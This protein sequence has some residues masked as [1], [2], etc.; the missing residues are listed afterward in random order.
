MVVSTIGK[1]IY[2]TVTKKKNKLPTGMAKTAK[3]TRM[4]G[5]KMATKPKPK[6]TKPKTKGY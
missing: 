4:P 1:K 6:I 5:T 3:P 2:K